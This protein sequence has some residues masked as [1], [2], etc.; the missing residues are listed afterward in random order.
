M[1]NLNP[2]EKDQGKKNQSGPQKEFKHEKG[3]KGPGGGDRGKSSQQHKESRSQPPSHKNYRNPQ[4][5][6]GQSGYKPHGQPFHQGPRHPQHQSQNQNVSHPY[7]PSSIQ[8]PATSFHQSHGSQGSGHCSTQYEHQSWSDGRQGYRFPPPS[9]DESNRHLHQQVGMCPTPPPMN[10]NL[11]PEPQFVNPPPPYVA[12]Q[13]PEPRYSEEKQPQME[14]KAK[15]TAEDLVK[16]LAVFDGQWGTGDSLSR[17]VQ[18]SVEEVN[19]VVKSRSDIFSHMVD[20]N[21]IIIE[22]VP[23]V[24]LCSDYLSES[25][26]VSRDSCKDLHLCKF[27]ITGSCKHG[28]SCQFGHRLDTNHNSSVLSKL[29]LDLISKHVLYNVIKKVFRGNVSPQICKF[30]NGKKGCLKKEKC[31]SLHIC[32]E[33]V[34][35]VGK[36]SN[37]GCSLNHDI[38]TEHCKRHLRRCGISLN[39]SPRD[40]LLNLKSSLQ[41]QDDDDEST[42]VSSSQK[43]RKSKGKEE[44]AEKLNTKRDLSHDSRKKLPSETESDSDSSEQGDTGGE[45]ES[46]K[47]NKGKDK[48]KSGKKTKT[49]CR[50][51]DVCGDVEIPEICIYAVNDK[52]LN[53]KKGCRYLHAKSLFHWQ[54]EKDNNWYNFRVFHSKALEKAYRDVTMGSVQLAP[55]DPETLDT[56]EKDM[57]KVLGKELWTVDFRNMQIKGASESKILKIRRISTRSAAVFDNPKATVYD[58]YYNDEQGKWICFGQIDSLGKQELAC[59]ITCEE[60]EKQYLSDPSSSMVI[61]NVHFKYKLNFKDMT[62]TNLETSKVTEIRRRPTGLSYQKKS[63]ASSDNTS[64]PAYWTPMTPSQTHVLVPLDPSKTEFQEVSSRLRL[65]NPTAIIQK[66]QRLQNPYLWCLLQQKKA[67]LSLR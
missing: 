65:T 6:G 31:G 61:S 10:F 53:E 36:C 20:G 7:H 47:K 33:Y 17:H 14:D 21:E 22:L 1:T 38:F 56:R 24:N 54:V 45:K 25:S 18:R 16:A 34:R 46:K 41:N 27:F 57:L 5:S 39:E 66:I 44:D 52:C 60:I 11:N 4:S 28:S 32:E 8:R 29:Y 13:R 2:K 12:T 62:Q 42:D 40:I 37:T 50:S 23:K 67:S 63:A 30:Y 3:G 43:S 9:Y 19:E 15:L 55:L 58:W 51:T 48:E 49:T 64:N 26:C 35:G 59:P